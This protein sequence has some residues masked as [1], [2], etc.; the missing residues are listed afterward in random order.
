MFE[1][2]FATLAEE[3]GM[4]GNKK[5]NVISEYQSFT[6]LEYSKNKVVSAIQ[7]VP[8]TKGVVA[9]ACTEPLSFTERLQR[10]GRA[11]NSAILI[12]NFK[13]PI[14]PD[15]VLESPFEVQLM[16]KTPP[17]RLIVRD[18]LQ[19]R[20][21]RGC[22]RGCISEAMA[23]VC[24]TRPAVACDPTPLGTG[25]RAASAVPGRVLRR[26]HSKKL[27]GRSWHEI[28]QLSIKASDA[29]R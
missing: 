22:C 29:W 6:D 20:F 13:D 7:W 10:D 9:V 2:D 25:L 12:W 5:E 15:Y 3:D 8:G 14:H 24:S 1:D 19:R 16:P 4:S 11:S 28:T 21:F 17:P 27:H 23:F 18:R 26:G